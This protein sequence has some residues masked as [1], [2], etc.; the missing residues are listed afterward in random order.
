MKPSDFG[1]PQTREAY[2][3]YRRQQRA[4]A[5][6]FFCFALLMIL[7]TLLFTSCTA[8]VDVERPSGSRYSAA[9]LI[10]TD[11]S[12]VSR[13]GSWKATGV[14]NSDAASIVKKAVVTRGV[15]NLA[16][17]AVGAAGNALENISKP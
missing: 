3:I 4:N 17:P 5:V 9:V 8:L 15:L 16:T 2:V 1:L 11:A 12:E 13:E 10:G 6:G 14:N 7:I